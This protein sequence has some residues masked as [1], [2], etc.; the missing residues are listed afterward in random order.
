M[1]RRIIKQIIVMLGLA[2][3]FG[4]CLQSPVKA[5]SPIKRLDGLAKRLT[6]SDQEFESLELFA[7]YARTVL[8]YCS[9]RNH[10]KGGDVEC[11][12]RINDKFKKTM[13][14]VIGIQMYGEA[15]EKYK[16]FN[17]ADSESYTKTHIRAIEIMTQQLISKGYCDPS[18]SP[19]ICFYDFEDVWSITNKIVSSCENYEK[20]K[21]NQNNEGDLCQDIL[22]NERSFLS[23]EETNFVNLKHSFYNS[24]KNI[25]W[26]R[27]K[28]ENLHLR[29]EDNQYFRSASAIDKKEEYQNKFNDLY[30]SAA[31]KSTKIKEFIL[32]YQP[33]LVKEKEEITDFS[34]SGNYYRTY[35]IIESEKEVFINEIEERCSGCVAK[36][37][38]LLSNQEFLEVMHI[39]QTINKFEND[40]KSNKYEN[41]REETETGIDYWLGILQ[42]RGNKTLTANKANL[43]TMKRFLEK[44]NTKQYEPI[45]IKETVPKKNRID[46]VQGGMGGL[47][48][49][50]SNFSITVI[51]SIYDFINSSSSSNLVSVLSDQKSKDPIKSIWQFFLNLSSVIL[52]LAFLTMIFSQLTGIGMSNYASKKILPRMI[53]MVILSFSSF[54]LLGI[55]VDLSNI[56]SKSIYDILV[57]AAGS[58]NV[59]SPGIIYQIFDTAITVIGLIVSLILAIPAFLFNFVIFGMRNAILVMVASTAPFFFIIS[60]FPNFKKLLTIWKQGFVLVLVLGPAIA[61]INSSSILIYKIL[62]SESVLIANVALMG[63]LIISP[64]MLLKLFKKMPILLSIPFAGKVLGVNAFSGLAPAKLLSRQL[65]LDNFA[66]KKF[67]KISKSNRSKSK[68]RA[69]AEQKKENQVNRAQSANKISQNGAQAAL[70]NIE[71]NKSQSAI[72]SADRSAFDEI[73]VDSISKSDEALTHLL[74]YANDKNNDNNFSGKFFL[75]NMKKAKQLGASQEDLKITY[76]NAISNLKEKNNLVAVADLESNLKYYNRQYGEFNNEDYN[77]GTDFQQLREKN[78]RQAFTAMPLLNADLNKGGPS[79]FL[80]T[81]MLV[82]PLHQRV[83]NDL[84]TQDERF[85]NEVDKNMPLFNANLKNKIN[86]IKGDQ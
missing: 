68:G 13:A 45:E 66:Q 23:S 41:G 64:F 35:S 50:I 2:V 52:I 17:L 67:R 72:P 44:I 25:Q 69:G 29:I 61:L 6:I 80:S 38:K 84:Y 36:I 31:I 30:K 24:F 14:L 15:N 5:E 79:S 73:K 28:K 20:S 55:A 16:E 46:Y 22:A 27:Q 58:I 7:K 85:K 76:D 11:S 77:D 82:D 63:N 86:D 60:I 10:R 74:A 75:E 18:K 48:E 49:T 59:A 65:G 83:F 12:N 40:K 47:L 32:N 8:D 9:A 53:I 42:N 62:A 56:F 3:C 39:M 21:Q 81:S 34:G 70:S 57:S 19:L 1:I 33:V 54:L 26:F 78:V 43:I 4:F 37:E 71:N 51:G